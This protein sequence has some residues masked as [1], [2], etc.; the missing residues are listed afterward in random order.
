MG[1]LR[2][3][4]DWE[5]EEVHLL[6]TELERK[7]QVENREDALQWK[8]NRKG[9]FLVK[10]CYNISHTA[11]NEGMVLPWGRIIPPRLSFFLLGRFGGVGS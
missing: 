3:I 5:L 8:P 11:K 2:R 7:V 9:I 4:N 6:Y 1:L 10:S